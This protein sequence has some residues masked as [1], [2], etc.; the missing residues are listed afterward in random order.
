MHDKVITVTSVNI[1]E[2]KGTVKTPVPEITLNN[3]GVDKDAHAG[4][5]H[6]QVSILGQEDVNWFSEKFDRVVK[7]GEFAENI[8]LEG[9]DL[10][11]VA[12]LDRFRIGEVVLEITQIGKECHGDACAIFREVGQCVM[13]KKGLF[14]RVVT[15]GPVRAGDEAEYLP[16][17]FKAVVITMSDRASRGEYEDRSGPRV[18]KHLEDFFAG[19]RWH[20]ECGY[21]L[22]PDDRELLEKTL[23][24]LKD[25]GCDLVITTGGTGIGPRDFTP[26][27][28]LAMADREIP[29]IM[30]AVRLKFGAKKPNALLSRSVACVMGMT[31]VYALPGSVKAVDEYM[32]EIQKTV[33]HIVGMLHG[34]GH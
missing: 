26:D 31:Q 7:P 17:P 13:P 27:A 4:D 18:R 5:W 23:A 16:R 6:R 25:E 21:H 32:G 9:I 15:G 19:K 24:Q 29:G 10:G 8:T 22:L 2:E 28:V 33:E 34:L 30:D 11:N 3:R 1:S 12:I 14:A 20:L